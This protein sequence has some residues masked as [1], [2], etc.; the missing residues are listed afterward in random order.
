MRPYLTEISVS[1]KD[2]TSS[3]TAQLTFDDA[4]GQCLLPKTGAR[5]SVFLQGVLAFQGVVDSTPWTMTRG[6]GRMLQVNAKGFDTRSKVKEGQQWHLDDGTLD[7]ALNK[8][9]K[10]AGLSGVSVD[11]ELGAIKRDYWTPD[12]ASFMAFAEKLARQH[13][14]TFKIRGDQAVFVKRGS[15]S[16]GAGAAM[17]TVQARIPGNVISCSVDPSKGRPRYSKARARW[18]DRKSAS[19]KTKE[20]EIETGDDEVDVSDEVR[21]TAADEEQAGGFVEGHKSDS[22]REGG[23]GTIEMDLTVDAQAEGTLVLSGARPGVDGTYRIVS[24]THKA[25]RSSGATTTLEIKQPQGD[26]GKDSREAE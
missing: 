18:F 5:V 1:D 6:G 19:F 7:D 20:I 25:T 26:A 2:G 22:E 16:N 15:G 24:V 4:G 8:A 17:P 11:P 13:G 3:D 21:G 10:V 9:A 12:G 14:A 23:D